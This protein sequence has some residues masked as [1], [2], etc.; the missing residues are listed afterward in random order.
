MVG[1]QPKVK[2]QGPGNGCL[3]VT[4]SPAATAAALGRKHSLEGKAATHTH[5]A[6]LLQLAKN[7]AKTGRKN[8][9]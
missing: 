1:H 7:R 9:E 3:A 5:R 4:L 8:T 2:P 6:Q